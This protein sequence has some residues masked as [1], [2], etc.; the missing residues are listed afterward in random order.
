MTTLSLTLLSNWMRL[1]FDPSQRWRLEI[2]KSH[3]KPSA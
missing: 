1:A 3:D 2:G